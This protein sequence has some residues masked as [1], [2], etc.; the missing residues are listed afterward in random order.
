VLRQF[1]REPAER[2]GKPDHHPAGQQRLPK[3]PAQRAIV[4]QLPPRVEYWASISTL[5]PRP[6]P[7]GA[8]RRKGGTAPGN[9]AG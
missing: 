4:V 3:R 8:A 5:V 9:S 7:P 6:R 1:R 2:D